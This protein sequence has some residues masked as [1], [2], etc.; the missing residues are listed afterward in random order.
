M[1]ADQIETYASTI[2]LVGVILMLVEH[3]ANADAGAND[4]IHESKRITS[5]HEFASTADLPRPADCRISFEPQRAPPGLSD[6]PVGSTLTEIGVKALDS[7]QVTASTRGPFKPLSYRHVWC[8]ALLRRRKR[9]RCSANPRSSLIET[10]RESPSH[11][12]RGNQ[13]VPQSPDTRATRAMR[14][15]SPRPS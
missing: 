4:S 11:A 3:S 13:G 2:H 8:V 1:N 6:D 14:A 7:Q 10:R 12:S 15:F 5:D 9:P